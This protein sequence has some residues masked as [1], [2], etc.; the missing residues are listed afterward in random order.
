MTLLRY[1]GHSHLTAGE[2]NTQRSRKLSEVMSVVIICL[3]LVELLSSPQFV[4]ERD[5]GISRMKQLQADMVASFSCSFDRFSILLY[6]FVVALRS[7]L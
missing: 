7:M 3:G 2:E 6:C 5:V 1:F 4:I